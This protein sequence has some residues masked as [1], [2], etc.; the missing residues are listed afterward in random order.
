MPITPDTKDWTWVIDRPCP[1][2][3]FDARE[4]DRALVGRAVRENAAAWVLILQRDDVRRRPREDRWSDLEYACHVRDVYRLFDQRLGLMLAEDD[5]EFANWDQDET[6]VAERYD[7]Q[8]PGSVAR[9]ILE[10]GGRCADRFDAVTD[11]QWSRPGRRSNGS[12]FTVE[13]IGVYCLHDTFHH[14]WDVTSPS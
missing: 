9:E 2:C 11:D 6:A 14:L 1:E 5:P 8:D 10:A 12:R 3:G 4:V 7:L 13:S